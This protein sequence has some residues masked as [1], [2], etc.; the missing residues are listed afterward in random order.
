MD[1]EKIILESIK[2]AA[3]NLQ[4]NGVSPEEV[5]IHSIRFLMELYPPEQGEASQDQEGGRQRQAILAKAML[6]AEAYLELGFPYEGGRELFEQVFHR[7]GLTEDEVRSFQ[8]RCAGKLKL[9]KTQIG[10]VLGRWNP[11]DHSDT[12]QRVIEDIMEKV[13]NH[14]QGEYFYYTRR[15]YPKQEDIYQLAVE[16]GGSYLCHVNRQKY[17]VFEDMR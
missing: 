7:A 11:K 14:E 3:A 5:I 12:K 8:R 9:N 10:T 6:L 2:L 15:K 1:K 17:Y 13:R 16:P 4:L